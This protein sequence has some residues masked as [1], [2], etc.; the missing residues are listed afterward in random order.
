MDAEHTVTET[1][2]ELRTN[3]ECY[4]QGSEN[5]IAPYTSFVT[6][7]MMGKS[8]HM[9]E[10]ANQLP[11]VYICLRQD[12]TGF[13]YPH[14]SPSIAVWSSKGAA[15]LLSRAGREFYF[16]FSTFR[17]SAFILSTILNLATWIRSGR[18]FTSLRIDSSEPRKFKYAWLWA[19]FAEPPIVGELKDFWVEVEKATHSMLRRYPTGLLAHSYLQTKHESAVRSALDTLRDC[20]EVHGIN[21]K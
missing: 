16:C 7:S 15:T 13:G 9:K 14:R 18:F 10:V 11:C 4:A 6:S 2:K 21:D 17:W 1:V 12:P 8:R 3:M 20:F 19:F 5:Y